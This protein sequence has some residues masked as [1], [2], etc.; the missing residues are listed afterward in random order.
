MLV[1]RMTAKHLFDAEPGELVRTS[2]PNGP[3]LG[4]MAGLHYND[5]QIRSLLICLTP[6]DDR[7]RGP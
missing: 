3:I 1:P 2:G 4:L 7:G 6:I 5:P